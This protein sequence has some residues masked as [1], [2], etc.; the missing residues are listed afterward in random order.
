MENLAQRPYSIGRL[1]YC[2]AISVIL[3]WAPFF[4]LDYIN[5][6]AETSGGWALC[7]AF[8]AVLLGV[9][10]GT[11]EFQ[12]MYRRRAKPGFKFSYLALALYVVILSPCILILLGMLLDVFRD[13]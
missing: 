7:Y 9:T 11:I 10:I 12:K 6:K 1:I 5:P 2:A 8:P 4:Y 3:Y 13:N